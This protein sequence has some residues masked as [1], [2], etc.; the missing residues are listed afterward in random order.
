MRRKYHLLFILLQNHN[1]TPLID[2]LIKNKNN[3]NKI[4]KKAKTVR[5]YVQV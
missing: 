3:K 4:K 1:R 5:R 2:T